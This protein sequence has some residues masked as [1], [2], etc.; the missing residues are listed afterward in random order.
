M[1]VS[2]RKTILLISKDENYNYSE[3]SL[4]KAYIEKAEVELQLQ[5]YNYLSE[6]INDKNANGTIIS[7]SV[8]GITDQVFS[9]LSMNF[10][11]S[12]RKKKN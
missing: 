10:Q 4:K 2:G 11:L 3:Q 5:Y 12:S 9:N 7:P 6:Y 8:I 1:R